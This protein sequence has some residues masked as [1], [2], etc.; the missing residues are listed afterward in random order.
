M[1]I[2][3]QALRAIPEFSALDDTE[4]AYVQQV[5]RERQIQRGELLLLEGEPGERLYYILAGRVKV[6]TT[7]ADG[8]EQ[9]LRIFQAGE[10]FNEVPIFDGGPNPASALVLEDGTAYVLHRADIQRLLSEHP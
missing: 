4:L 8:K 6:F 3:I 7:S 5:T 2:E 9:V 10:T 1:T